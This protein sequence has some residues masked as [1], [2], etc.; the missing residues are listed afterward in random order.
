MDNL[1]VV[2]EDS[3]KKR[4]EIYFKKIDKDIDVVKTLQDTNFTSLKF[5]SNKV[6]DMNKNYINFNDV[7]YNMIDRTDNAMTLVL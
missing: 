4:D 3:L 7:I 5:L 6:F 2:L 1:V